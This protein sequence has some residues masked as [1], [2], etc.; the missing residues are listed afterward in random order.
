MG[1]PRFFITALQTARY[2]NI[3]IIC[4]ENSYHYQYAAAQ[5]S[6]YALK[7]QCPHEDR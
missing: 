3:L 6:Q 4:K 5:R 7:G 1:S 2:E